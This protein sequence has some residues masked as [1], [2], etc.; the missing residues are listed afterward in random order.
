MPR[1]CA[2]RIERTG[3]PR[4][5]TTNSRLVSSSA[6]PRISSTSL[7]KNR[8][9]RDLHFRDT[10][11]D[12]PE[13]LQLI[14]DAHACSE[15]RDATR[16]ETGSRLTGALFQLAIRHGEKSH[17]VQLGA[18]IPGAVKRAREYIDAHVAANPSLEVL[19]EVAGVNAFHL[20]R[21]F[22]KAFGI[23]PHGYLIQRRVEVAKHLLLKGKPLRSVAIEVGYYD[24]GHLS[25][26]FS[27][28]F[29]VPPSATR[30]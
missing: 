5:R 25:R 24:Q 9:A 15:S 4:T 11:I 23:A 8:I 3:F 12:D 14:H 6:A 26:E 30:Q 29:G 18:S 28:F 16:L 17:R 22:K 21:E 10:V 7:A 27:R 20:L 19:A 2:R 1:C 13:T